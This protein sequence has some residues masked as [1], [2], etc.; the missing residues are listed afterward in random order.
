MD[1][2]SS[3]EPHLVAREVGLNLRAAPGQLL[4]VESVQIDKLLLTRRALPARGTGAV[5]GLQEPGMKTSSKSPS[6]LCA[7]IA[8]RW[9]RL[10]KPLAVDSR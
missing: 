3:A 1:G 9:N 8:N 2:C 4:V 6:P 7:R 5:L 10:P